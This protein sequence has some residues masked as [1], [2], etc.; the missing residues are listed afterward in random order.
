MFF[1][2]RKKVITHSGT[3]H[4]D[5]LFA[6]ATLYL[7]FKKRI[8]IIRTR[9]ES[10]IAGGDIVVDVGGIYDTKTM[11]FDHH[12]VG[13]GGVR[14]NGIPYASFGLVWK[15]FGESLTGSKEVQARLDNRLVA[16]VDALD[17][18]VVLSTPLREDVY[19]YGLHDLLSA[20]LPTW[21]ETFDVDLVFR[22]LVRVA[23]QVLEHEIKK[24]KDVIL[25]EQKIR[26]IYEE[27]PDKRVIILDQYLPWKKV[28]SEF[29]EP[30]IVAF[31]E[32]SSGKWY[33]QGTLV[34]IN[35]N[36]NRKFYFPEAWA[37]LRDE[38]LAKISGVKD[39]V[40]CHRGQFLIVAKS[41]EGIVALIK[42]SL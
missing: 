41:K 16:P 2:P 3:F 1:T 25:G 4:E 15:E 19:P 35:D 38:E 20:F 11:R 39:A 12:Q 26:N 36:F 28:L 14:P 33:A 10:V 40:F 8:R 9:D 37:G 7:Y 22:K 18:G 27:V 34:K 21:N 23:A 13:G 29:P 32:K 6:C 5:D 42:K 31:P 30:I 24:T 17:N